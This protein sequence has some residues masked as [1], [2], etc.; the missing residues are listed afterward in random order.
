MRFRA[1]SILITA[2]LAGTASATDPDIFDTEVVLPND[3]VSMIL[4]GAS[5]NNGEIDLINTDDGN[6]ASVQIANNGVP[7]NAGDGRGN[8]DILV[9]WRE[10]FENGPDQGE[11]SRIRFNITTS[12]GDPIIPASDFDS[13]FNFVRWEIGDHGDAGDQPFAD[14]IGFRPGVEEITLVEATVVF[15]NNQTVLNSVQYGFTIGAG[16]DWDGTDYNPGNI[17]MV[18]R[19]V[20]RIQITYDYTPIPAPA[21]IGA[22]A[23]AGL[24]ASRRRRR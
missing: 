17:F 21:G 20:N 6:P 8:F 23:A 4:R 13:G 22:L 11:A 18:D 9:N 2:G 3:R 24:F 1:L 5:V 14:P 19:A 10:F 7:Q 12:S 15:F 16:S